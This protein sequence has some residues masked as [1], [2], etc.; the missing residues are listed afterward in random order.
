MEA[1]VKATQT[2]FIFVK[3]PLLDYAVDVYERC[4]MRSER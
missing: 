1:K 2:D 4:L 3:F